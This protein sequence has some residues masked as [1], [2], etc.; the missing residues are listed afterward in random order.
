MVRIATSGFTKN[1]IFHI[2][3]VHKLTFQNIDLILDIK[4]DKLIFKYR[5]LNKMLKHS[6]I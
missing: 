1:C 4:K 5:S 3:K 2:V 6:E